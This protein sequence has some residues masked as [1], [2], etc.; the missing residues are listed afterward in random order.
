MA[1]SQKKTMV[2]RYAELLQETTKTDAF[3]SEANLISIVVSEIHKFLE[4]DNVF[5]SKE[6]PI[7]AGIVD[8]VAGHINQTSPRRNGHPSLGAAG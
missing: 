1:T 4:G 5:A 3:E 8:V 2:P 7:G 6:L